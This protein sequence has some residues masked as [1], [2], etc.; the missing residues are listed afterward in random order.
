MKIGLG[1]ATFF[2]APARALTAVGRT[3][4]RRR[5]FPRRAWVPISRCV[6]LVGAMPGSPWPIPTHGNFFSFSGFFFP[7]G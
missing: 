4:S 5:A 7:G 6:I 3:S 1:G 2:V